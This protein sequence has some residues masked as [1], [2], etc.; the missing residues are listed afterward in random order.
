MT[1]RRSRE[2]RPR[3]PVDLGRLVVHR[4]RDGGV[5]E[6]P[7]DG[8]EAGD[9]VELVAEVVEEAEGGNLRRA[10]GVFEA[11]AGEADLRIRVEEVDQF[12]EGA[13]PDDRVVVEEQD[14]LGRVGGGE[15]GADHRVV[16]AGEAEVRRD[17]GEH[18]PGT[19]ARPSM[20]AA[21]RSASPG[22]SSVPGRLPLS[23]T[24]T[25]VPGTSSGSGRSSRGSRR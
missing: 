7:G 21:R 10:V 5:A 18:T 23:Q 3:D 13:G 8:A 24:P 19:V 4:Q 11:R 6:Q 17:R 20:K 14:L 2:R 1:S 12:F 15:G 16:A 9:G 25:A 22:A